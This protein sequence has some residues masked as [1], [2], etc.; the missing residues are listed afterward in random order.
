VRRF[1]T[2]QKARRGRRA[3]NGRTGVALLPDCQTRG[4]CDGSAGD[5]IFLHKIAHRSVHDTGAQKSPGALTGVDTANQ[6]TVRWAGDRS[7]RCTIW[8]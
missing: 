3:S 7:E 4:E 2:K 8:S 1:L 5:E 6:H